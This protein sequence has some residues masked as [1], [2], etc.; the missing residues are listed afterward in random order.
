VNVFLGLWLVTPQKQL[1]IL[2]T[3][4]NVRWETKAV[5]IMTY[6]QR[7]HDDYGLKCFRKSFTVFSFIHS[8]N[9][10]GRSRLKKTREKEDIK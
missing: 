7:H 1:P 5:N 3:D 6:Y 8:L 2:Q 9:H 4:V 10:S